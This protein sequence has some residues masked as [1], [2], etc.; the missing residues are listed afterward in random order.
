MLLFTIPIHSPRTNRK[1]KFWQNIS[2][3]ARETIYCWNCLFT[4][5][6]TH[7][8]MREYSTSADGLGGGMN[9]GNNGIGALISLPGWWRWH[10][11]T[12]PL[13]RHRLSR[14]LHA[15]RLVA[16]VAQLSISLGMTRWWTLLILWYNGWFGKER[17]LAGQWKIICVS[18]AFWSKLRVVWILNYCTTVSRGISFSFL[19]WFKYVIEV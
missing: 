7:I 17:L 10:P 15:G 19:L 18:L 5:L 8:C 3:P 11:P 14:C 16:L 2:S 1:G 9:D 13:L 6:W 12:P 4:V